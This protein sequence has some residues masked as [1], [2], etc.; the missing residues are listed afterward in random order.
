VVNI[1]GEVAAILAAV[2][3]NILRL[4]EE[5]AADE[6]NVVAAHRQQRALQQ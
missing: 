5:L 2:A 1:N 3:N 6:P 4:L